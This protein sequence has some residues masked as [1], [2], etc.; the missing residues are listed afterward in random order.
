VLPVLET[1]TDFT[2]LNSFGFMENSVYFAV[3]GASELSGRTTNGREF[4]NSLTGCSL[5]NEDISYARLKFLVKVYMCLVAGSLSKMPKDV[6]IKG[7]LNLCL[8]FCS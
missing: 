6:V 2:S 4:R 3:L 5:L 1:R 7:E 8:V